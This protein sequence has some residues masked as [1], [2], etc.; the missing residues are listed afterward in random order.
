MTD[1]TKPDGW[2]AS[3]TDSEANNLYQQH[4]AER[5]H[6]AINGALDKLAENGMP[7]IDVVKR[8]G[9]SGFPA[10]G[11]QPLP[12][13][14]MQVHEDP[15]AA[16]WKEAT[17]MTDQTDRIKQMAQEAGFGIGHSEAAATLFAKFAALVAEDCAR[18]CGALL[19][20][21]HARSEYDEYSP[22]DAQTIG[23]VDGINESVEH[24]RARY[25]LATPSQAG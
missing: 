22:S 5:L 19:D 2:G 21:C 23:W 24:I 14:P 6:G 18:V 11:V 4:M 13:E 8:D 9:F 1:Q 15:G 20:G 25:T 7:F 10:K 12:T 3:L 17:K 16:Y